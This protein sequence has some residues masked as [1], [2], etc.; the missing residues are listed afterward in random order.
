[1]STTAPVFLGIDVGTSG[2]RALAVTNDGSV[3]AL[4]GV[5]FPVQQGRCHEGHHEQDPDSWWQATCHATGR[6]MDQLKDL[7]VSADALQGAAVDGTS[8]TLVALDATR[9]PVRSALMYNDLRGVEQAKRLNEIASEFLARHGYLFS[10]S[11]AAAKILWFRENEPHA[12]DGT[13]CFAHQADYVASRLTGEAIVSDFNNALK[14]GYDLLEDCWPA[15]LATD[16]AVGNRLPHVVEPGHLIGQI[17]AIGSQESGLPA[18]LPIMAGTTDGVAACL[19]SGMQSP[20]EYNTTLGTTLVFKGLSDR[21]CSSPGGLV[22]SHKLPGARWLPGAASN[23][24]AEWI[25][26]WF[27]AADLARMDREAEEILPTAPIAYPLARQGE[28]FPFSRSDAEGFGME[29][30]HS[31]RERYAS[32]LLGTALV[33]RLAYDVL[34]RVSGQ[35]SGAVYA[36]G[37]GSRSDIWTQI[38]A[39][40]TGRVMHRPAV[41]ESAFG[42]ALLAASGVMQESLDRVIGRMVCIE[43]SFFPNVSRAALSE[44]RFEEFGKELRDRGYL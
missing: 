36:T 16:L 30:C 25:S 29:A 6:L 15:W 7:G 27:E 35:S 28:R 3:L 24:G 34:D 20:G 44:E 19:A 38:R 2:V 43:K 8:G 39:D 33:E 4:A 17:S 23:T 11:F 13:R 10:S 42:A 41:A 12:F 1:M 26:R 37:G 18:G 9:K 5:D 22:Y 21:I 14:T 31:E 40:V 32:C